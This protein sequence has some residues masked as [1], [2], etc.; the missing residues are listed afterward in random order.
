MDIDSAPAPQADDIEM[1]DAPPP[2]RVAFTPPPDYIRPTTSRVAVNAMPPK[3]ALSKRIHLINQTEDDQYVP[4]EPH[5]LDQD[6]DYSHPELHGLSTAGETPPAKPLHATNTSSAL[7]DSFSELSPE[8]ASTPLPFSPR[9]VPSWREAPA[10]FVPNWR[11]APAKTSPPHLS[12][13]GRPI[14]SPVSPRVIKSPPARVLSPDTLYPSLQTAGRKRTSPFDFSEGPEQLAQPRTVLGTVVGIIRAISTK[15][16]TSIWSLFKSR[17]SI[18][19]EIIAVHTS[20]YKRRAIA[21]Q[22]IETAPV[23]GYYPGSEQELRDM[24]LQETE[25]GTNAT[26]IATPPDS[27]PGSKENSPPPQ[28]QHPVP[29][30]SPPQ[31]QAIAPKSSTSEYIAWRHMFREQRPIQPFL[32]NKQTAAPMSSTSKDIASGHPIQG[33]MPSRHIPQSNRQTAVATGGTLKHTASRPQAQEEKQVQ[34]PSRAHEQTM[35]PP[36][37][38]NIYT[39]RRQARPG[40][41]L[42]QSDRAERNRDADDRVDALTKRAKDITILSPEEKALRESV[43]TR[44]SRIADQEALEAKEAKAKK[45]EEQARLLAEREAEEE[46]KQAEK[47][48]EIAA[49][50][51]AARLA[52]RKTLIPPTSSEW[53]QKI[54]ERMATRDPTKILGHDS[55]GGELTRKTLGC[56]LPQENEHLV[57]YAADPTAKREPAGWMNDAGVDGFI[58]AIVD[59]RREQDGYVKGQGVPAFA[60]F[61]CQWFSNVRKNGIK[62]IARWGRR[63][64]ISEKKLLQCEKIF[65]PVNTGA[66]WVLLVLSPKERTMEFL[67]SAGGSGRTFF[68]LARE[69]LDMELGM[70]YVAEEWTELSSKSETQQNL[71]DCGVFTCINALASAK[72]ADYSAVPGKDMKPAREFIASVLLNGGFSEELDL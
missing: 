14:I 63:Q 64:Q 16:T 19:Q 72:G 36:S 15:L 49:A 4:K 1:E 44:R 71:D 67:D 59:R 45:A 3:T 43:R 48:A 57:K 28:E 8:H 50:K 33:Q 9:Y 24:V 51:E 11:I 68:K 21:R 35:A 20:A 5:P 13:Q 26:T 7:D 46:R 54:A 30:A 69:W 61:S 60:N 6:V 41:L 58:S 37:R 32:R 25:Q 22:D 42:N 52:A 70:C 53:Q 56:I 39:V 29:Q 47:E 17:K 2:R 18:E 31:K 38:R 27:R 12:P 66:H 10:R 23:P 34:Q 65:F 62:S 55:R 40:L